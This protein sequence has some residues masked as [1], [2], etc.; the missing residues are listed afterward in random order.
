MDDRNN[1]GVGIIV[2]IIVI[3]LLGFLAFWWLSDDNDNELDDAVDET[4]STIENND[5]D[6]S[7][8]SR[9]VDNPADYY[10]QTVTVQGEIQDVYD[11]RVFSISDQAVG[12]E[13]WVVTNTPLTSS[14]QEEAEPLFA[15]NANV[16]VNGEV[17]QMTL[18]Q[19][20]EEFSLDIPAQIEATF[21]DG[22]VLVADSFT[23]TSSGDSLDFTE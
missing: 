9:I 11:S 22:P 4:Q 7:I 20:E 12:D 19:I 6:D 1:N 15:D 5:N 23:F 3:L 13:L 14:Q 17:R 21:S 2:T 8:L 18:A 16:T 10:D